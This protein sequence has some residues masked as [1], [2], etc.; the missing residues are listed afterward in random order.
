MQRPWGYN[1]SA[2]RH[3]REGTRGQENS[4]ILHVVIG[5]A[6]KK[7]RDKI[8]ELSDVKPPTRGENTKASKLVVSTTVSIQP[9][10]TSSKEEIEA[11]A[12]EAGV[13]TSNTCVLKT[14]L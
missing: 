4:D 6:D 8:L 11:F 1:L 9:A 3:S 7:H 13:E 14:D 5:T 2:S 12:Q 10:I